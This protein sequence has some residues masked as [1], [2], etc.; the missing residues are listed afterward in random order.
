VSGLFD[1]AQGWFDAH[2][3]ALGRRSVRGSLTTGPADRDKR[4]IWVE[5]ESGRRL[6]RVVIWDSGEAVLTV[7]DLESG[8][9]VVEEQRDLTGRFGVEQ[10]LD[11]ALAWT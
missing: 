7:G 3:L 10:T 4:S 2:A 9:V 8:E 6:V 5:F 11:D 1:H